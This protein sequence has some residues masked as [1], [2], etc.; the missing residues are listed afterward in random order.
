MASPK[1]L[2]E[3]AAK[4]DGDTVKLTAGQYAGKTA[5][6]NHVGDR[7]VLEEI[8]GDTDTTADVTAETFPLYFSPT[9]GRRRTRTKRR[10]LRKKRTVKRLPKRK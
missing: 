7:L 2:A 4:E 3:L 5:Y 6:V 9:G 10:V 1:T 8:G